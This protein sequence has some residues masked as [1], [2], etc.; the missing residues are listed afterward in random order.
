MSNVYKR[1]L[2]LILGTILSLC[3]LLLHAQRT[4]VQSNGFVTGKVMIKLKPTASLLLQKSISRLSTNLKT[5]NFSTG[6]LHFDAVARQ[7]KATKMVRV[8]PNAGRME[9]RQ[10]KYG[11]DRWYIVQVD[12]TTAIPTAISSFRAIAEVELVQ[13]AYAINSITSPITK[14]T[15]ANVVIK[16]LAGDYSCSE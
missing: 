9:A 3:C 16:P 5:E 7:F 6:I 1:S 11:L 4:P 13:P 2:Q 10:H 8:F 12:A 15:S 14:I